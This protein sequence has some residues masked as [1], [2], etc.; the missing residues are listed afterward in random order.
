[1]GASK[2]RNTKPPHTKKG[3]R[4]AAVNSDTPAFRASLF[5]QQPPPGN[6]HG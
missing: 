3:N 4:R 2:G 1:M 5:P 6:R